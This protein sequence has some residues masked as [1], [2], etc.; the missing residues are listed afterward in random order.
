MN[1]KKLL[2]TTDC[3]LPRWDGIARFLSEIIPEL[4]KQFDVTVI[5]PEFGGKPFIV[6]GVRLIKL[7]VYSLKFGDI[8]FS[9]FKYKLIKKEVEKADLIFNQTLGPIGICAIIAGQKKKKIVSYV[10]SIEWELASEGAKHFHRLI[11]FFVKRIA[12][13]L[14]NKCNMLMVPSREVRSILEKNKIWTKKEVV[15]LGVDVE[16]FKP[17]FSKNKAKEK[18]EIAPDKIVIGFV[19]RFGREKDV[20]TL[21]KAFLQIN[22]KHYNTMLL[23]VGQGPLKYKHKNI[24][25]PGAQKDVVPYLQAM[26]IF[27]LPSLTETSSLS[28]MEAMSCGVAV[29]A[30]PVGNVKKYVKEGINGSLFPI[31]DVKALVEKIEGLILDEETLRKYGEEGRKMIEVNYNWKDTVKKI[32]EIMKNY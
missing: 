21:Y 18:I 27:A 32:I 9:R 19:G 11:K 6:P 30:T 2:I 7:P 24:I 25:M 31:R 20:H 23:L 8:Y 28:T 15:K 13:Y 3:F 17:F 16:K 5:A 26:D 4:K 14:Y 12:R 22:K 1:K 29:V 10:H